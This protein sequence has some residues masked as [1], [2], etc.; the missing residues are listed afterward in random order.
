MQEEK[1]LIYRLLYQVLI[2]IREESHLKENKK[3]HALS[4]LMHNVPLKLLKAESDDD[5]RTILKKIE[6]KADA[7]EIRKWYDNAVKQL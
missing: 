5:F 2:E 6:E 7:L 4:N 3:I 1:Q